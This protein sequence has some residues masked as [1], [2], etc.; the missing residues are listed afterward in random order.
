MILNPLWTD[1]LNELQQQFASA[2]PFR[3]VQIPSFFSEA[4][5]QQLLENFPEFDAEHARNEMGQ[6]GRK[7]VR[8][9]VRNLGPVYRQLDDVLRSDDFLHAI[10]QITG[11]ADLRYDPAYVGGGTHDNRSG[12]GLSPHVDFN[13]HPLDGRHRR[14]NLIVYLNQTWESDWGGC[15]ELHENPWSL[16]HN[17]VTEVLP[18]LNRAILFETNEHSWHGFQ[19]IRQPEDGPMLARRSFALYLYT[20]TRPEEETAIE[21]STVYVPLHLPKSLK[22]ADVDPQ[23]RDEVTGMLENS[24][25]MLKFLYDREKQFAARIEALKGLQRLP[26]TGQA[27]QIG[28]QVGFHDD[29][30]MGPS[31]QFEVRPVRRIRTIVLTLTIPTQI[32]DTQQ[33]TLTVGERIFERTCAAGQTFRWTVRVPLKRNRQIAISLEA[34]RHFI[35]A[36]HGL[37]EDRRPLAVLIRQLDLRG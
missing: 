14:L 28:R 12:Q 3:H 22:A 7:A 4:F 32:G 9:D 25:G 15:L 19:A 21:H 30:W 6:V 8:S 1:S 17:R 26:L 37:G 10:E 24:L 34:Q 27:L 16:H 13:Y 29:G 18:S 33:L 11:I 31:L 20:D 2:Q 35:P 23:V 36:E 5:C